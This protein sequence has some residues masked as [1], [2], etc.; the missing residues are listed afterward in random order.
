VVS[1]EGID[2]E[3]RSQTGAEWLMACRAQDPSEARELSREGIEAYSAT[4]RN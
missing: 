3:A 1:R 4:S 2:H